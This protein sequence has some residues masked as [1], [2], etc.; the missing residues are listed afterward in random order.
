MNNSIK[1]ED[2]L[3]GLNKEKPPIKDEVKVWMRQK[4]PGLF[5]VWKEHVDKQ[6]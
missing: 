2:F 3:N 1:M 5:P 4:Y 6:S